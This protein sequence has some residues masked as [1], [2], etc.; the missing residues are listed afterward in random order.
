MKRALQGI[1]AAVVVL[2]AYLLFWP[3]PIDPVAWQAPV[4]AG[5]VDPFGPYDRLAR[6]RGIG[7]GVRQ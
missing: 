4:N 1:G 7:L 5:Y 2:L 6:A 3:V